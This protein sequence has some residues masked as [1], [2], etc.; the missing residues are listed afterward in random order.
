MFIAIL[1]AY[2]VIG[3]GLGTLFLAV[4]IITTFNPDDDAPRWHIWV[5]FFF[6]TLLWPVA[7]RHIVRRTKEPSP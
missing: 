1:K 3:L 7:V 6:C 5:S 4:A 2:A